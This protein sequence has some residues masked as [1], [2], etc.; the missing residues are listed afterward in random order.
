MEDHRAAGDPRPRDGVLL[1]FQFIWNLFY[2]PLIAVRPEFRCLPVV[3]SSTIQEQT[4][5]GRNFA[6]SALATVPVV[7][8]FLALQR[9]YVQGVAAT[10]IKG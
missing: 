10:G 6:G 1:E 3:I 4:F 8:I 2:W 9:Y 7:V 5:W